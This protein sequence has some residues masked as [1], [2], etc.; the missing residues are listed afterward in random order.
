MFQDNLPLLAFIVGV[1]VVI[2]V[3]ARPWVATRGR[4]AI[5]AFCV[6]LGLTLLTLYGVQVSDRNT[7][8]DGQEWELEIALMGGATIVEDTRDQ[9]TG[10]GV[11]VVSESYGGLA[12]PRLTNFVFQTQSLDHSTPWYL[13]MVCGTFV[14]LVF[15][16]LPFG[17]AGRAHGR[18]GGR[19]QRAVNS[20]AEL[21]Q[22]LRDGLCEVSCKGCGYR[23]RALKSS[24]SNCPECGTPVRRSLQAA[25]AALCALLPERRGSRVMIIECVVG[26]I[27]GIGI[28]LLV[29][30]APVVWPA[31]FALWMAACLH[32]LLAPRSVKGTV[33]AS[34]LLMASAGCG[35]VLAVGVASAFG[36]GF[37]SQSTVFNWMFGATGYAVVVGLV[38]VAGVAF[39]KYLA[40]GGRRGLQKYR[41]HWADPQVQ[42]DS[43]AAPPPDLNDPSP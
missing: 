24:I 21:E 35:I 30:V 34:T 41:P 23:L 17:L 5:L 26:A 32:S 31:W 40:T 15:W 39:L 18:G 1:S 20:L 43:K 16:F 38:T 10:V 4:R 19:P 37:L 29:L 7:K 6:T 33:E 42:V 3:A 22:G 12:P 27:V 36:F 13:A 9:R 14:A 25:W 8:H 2:V 28:V 11:V